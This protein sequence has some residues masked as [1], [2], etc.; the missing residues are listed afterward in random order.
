MTFLITILV[1]SL[2]GIIG[3]LAAKAYGFDEK[4]VWYRN[5]REKAD[6]KIVDGFVLAHYYR[7]QFVVASG[8]FFKKSLPLF[9]AHLSSIIAEYVLRKSST[10][11]DMVKGRHV[12]DHAGTV[13]PFL[14]QVSQYKDLNIKKEE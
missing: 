5:F 1:I 10:V 6:A 7:H 11:V 3:M 13:S 4:Y 9:F 8:H 12:I 14:G 2:I